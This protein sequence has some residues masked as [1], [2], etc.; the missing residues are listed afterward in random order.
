MGLFL[1]WGAIPI[2]TLLFGLNLSW[3]RHPAVQIIYITG[4]IILCLNLP[5]QMYR[6]WMKENGPRKEG[7]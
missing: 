7:R 3:F 1:L 6:N 5:F 2:Y 4:M